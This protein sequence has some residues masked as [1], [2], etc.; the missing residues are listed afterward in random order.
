M[1]ARMNERMN[2]EWI[3]KSGQCL[4]E[5]SPTNGLQ[6]L[7][8]VKQTVSQHWSSESL[9]QDKERG[10]VPW[11]RWREERGEGGSAKTI[12][13]AVSWVNRKSKVMAAEMQFANQDQRGH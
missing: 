10:E 1:K 5:R 3:E 12:L 4:R 8:I 6:W 7:A 11:K 2:G 13:G 9:P